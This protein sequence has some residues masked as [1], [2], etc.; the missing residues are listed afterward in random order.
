MNILF[1]RSFLHCELIYPKFFAACR[2][3]TLLFI[4]SKAH[5]S[6]FS[7]NNS[8]W[9][10]TGIFGKKITKKCQEIWMIDSVT[11][12]LLLN[13]LGRFFARTV[14]QR[15]NELPLVNPGHHGRLLLTS[16]H[17]HWWAKK[18][19]KYKWMKNFVLLLLFFSNTNIKNM[20]LLL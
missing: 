2:K 11:L 14:S 6:I 17:F 20:R 15:N 10:V 16:F 9:N 5:S 13:G 4:S 19:F 8:Q 1:L 3:E 18:M 7:Y 12:F